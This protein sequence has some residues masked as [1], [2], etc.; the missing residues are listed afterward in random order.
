MSAC[1]PGQTG[2]CVYQVL[3]KSDLGLGQH[4]RRMC[5]MS[6]LEFMGKTWLKNKSSEEIPRGGPWEGLTMQQFHPRVPGF[7]HSR[8]D[9]NSVFLALTGRAEG[10]ESIQEA[11]SVWFIRELDFLFLFSWPIGVRM[12]KEPLATRLALPKWLLWK[13]KCMKINR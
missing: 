6:F 10:K 7:A 4:T 8:K 11:L 5:S 9:E 12:S 3:V 2:A 1:F 13:L